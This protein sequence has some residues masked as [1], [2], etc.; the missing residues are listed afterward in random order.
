MKNIITIILVFFLAY[1][2]NAQEVKKNKNAKIEF[3]VSGNC[4]MCEKRIEKAAL[5]VSGV[6]S[7]DWHSDCGTL[8]LILNEEK[9]DKITVQKAIAK[10]GHDN[11][12]QKSTDEIYSSLHTCCQ[13]VRK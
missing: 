3:H 6:K 5:S 9:T 13:Y 11:D 8:Y 7:A 4:A 1:N 12:G 10:V 2:A